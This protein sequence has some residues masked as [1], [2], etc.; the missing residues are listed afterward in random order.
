ME[1][2]V[3]SLKKEM[4]DTES[5]VCPGAHRALLGFIGTQKEDGP[6]KL[7]TE[8]GDPLP[9]A[10]EHLGCQELEDRRQDLPCR[11]WREHGPD[12]SLILNI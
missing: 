12:S 6:M 3:C 1:A 9:H 10:K 8:V 4:G 7:D 5:L 11:L 2:K